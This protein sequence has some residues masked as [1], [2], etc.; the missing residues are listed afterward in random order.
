[1]GQKAVQEFKGPVNLHGVGDLTTKSNHG[2]YQVKIPLHNGENAT[3][4][5]LSLEK[6]TTT[7]PSYPLQG[8]VEQDFIQAFKKT[9]KRI[10]KKLPKLPKFVGGDTDFMIGIRYLSYYPEKIFKLP[11]GLTIYESKFKNIDGTRGIVGG[12]Y[13]VFTEI[14]KHFYGS[15]E[16]ISIPTIQPIQNGISNKPR[17]LPSE[18]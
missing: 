12:P 16:N 2:I 14:E 3:M 11:I 9:K 4:S 13:H 8:E 5:G 17:H 1:M 15:P 7:F 6:I 18:N 10:S